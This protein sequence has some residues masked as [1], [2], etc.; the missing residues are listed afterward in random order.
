MEERVGGLHTRVRR[1]L[2]AGWSA[3]RV[4]ERSGVHNILI[5]YTPRRDK[6]IDSL[7]VSNHIRMKKKKN[8]AKHEYIMSAA[9]CHFG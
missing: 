2:C 5:F 8:T 3:W 6:I 1:G 7:W 4:A 9:I